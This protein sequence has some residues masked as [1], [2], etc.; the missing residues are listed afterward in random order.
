MRRRGFLASI[1]AFVVVPFARR[2]GATT[3]LKAWRI[4]E[5]DVYSGA[6]L[7]EAVA[8]AMKD[9][10]CP[11]ED[12]LDDGMYGFGEPGDLEVLME[13]CSYTTIGEILAG[14]KG[15]GM[16]CSYDC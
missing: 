16:V 12:V 5:Y 8:A 7:E 3:R 13:D 9:S 6:T 15:P 4:N 14:M 2:I 10:G 11:R 1:L